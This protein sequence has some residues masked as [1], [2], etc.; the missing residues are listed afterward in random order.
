MNKIK[1]L[2][3]ILVIGIFILLW[4]GIDIYRNLN[5][6][7]EYNL[8]ESIRDEGGIKNIEW[9][10]G[11]LVVEAIVGMGGVGPNSELYAKHK[12]DANTISLFVS[13][14]KI[15]IEEIFRNIP[16]CLGTYEVKFKIKNLEM[17]DY[18]ILLYKKSFMTENLLVDEKFI[19]DAK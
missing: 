12:V 8:D 5:L 4:S 2:I 10:E 18:K 19:S 11:I 3:G 17:K 14:E 9:I 15:F 6:D 13:D 7:F 16:Q 1:I